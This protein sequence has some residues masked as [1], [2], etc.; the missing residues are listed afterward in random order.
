MVLPLTDMFSYHA[1]H[2]LPLSWTWSRY[3]TDSVG[4]PRPLQVSSCFSEQ[5]ERRI[6]RR[7][8]VNDTIL[9]LKV[10]PATE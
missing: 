5:I 6:P 1:R 10:H 4:R 2:A 3:P 8:A 7:Q 9:R